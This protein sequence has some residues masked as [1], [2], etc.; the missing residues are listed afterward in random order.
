MKSFSLKSMLFGLFT[1]VILF[2]INI[3]P[4]TQRN[5]VIEYATGTWC[6]WC[7]CGDYTIDELLTQY[8]N[9]IPI[10]YHGPV[11]SDPFADF[12]GNEII[13]MMGFTGYPTATVDRS[14][15]LG[16]YTTWTAKVQSQINIPATVTINLDHNYNATTRQVNG[17]FY[18]TSLENLS[19]QFYLNIILTEDSLIYT[20]VNNG[21]CVSGGT[22]WVHNRVVRA[23]IN[24]ASGQ[25]VN[26]GSSWN[27]GETFNIPFSYTIPSEFQANNCKIIAFIYKQNSP[28]Y[29]AEVQQGESWE[30]VP[31]V[32]VSI[33]IPNGGEQ[34]YVGSNHDIIWSDTLS[35]NVKIELFK[36]DVF[37]STIISSTPSSGFYSWNIPDIQTP[38]D[39]YK[40][41]ISSLDYPSLNDLSDENFSILPP[42]VNL[43]FPNGGESLA[44]GSTTEITW[45]S[46]SVDSI[47]LEFSPDNGLSWETII[48]SIPSSGSYN[49]TVPNISSTSCLVKIS[50]T[51]NAAI[52]DVSD[53]TF[54]IYSISLQVISPNGGENWAIGS[55][56]TISWNSENVNNVKIEYS[57]NSGSNWITITNSLPNTGSYDWTIPAT[58]STNCLVRVWD[59]DHQWISDISDSPF[60]IYNIFI[61]VLSP[62]GGEQWVE[63][64]NHD[65]TYNTVNVTNVKIDYSTNSGTNWSN[66]ISS[67]PATGSY[68]WN[69]PN[70]PSQNCRIRIA[71]VDN[72]LSSDQ[73]DNNFLIVDFLFEAII[74]ADTIWLDQDYDGLTLGIV[75]GSSSYINS[76]TITNYEW[77]VN[78]TT[79]SNEITPTIE[80]TTGSNLVK[81]IVTSNTGDTSSDSIYISVYSAK[82]STGGSILSGVSQL[83][84]NFYVTSMNNGVYRIDSTGIILQSYMTGG[85]I[86]SSLCISNETGLM[87]VGS[88]DTRLYCFDSQLNSFWDR[89][90]GGVVDNAAGLTFSGGT[91]YVG[92][93]DNNTHLGFLKSLVADNGNPNWTFQADG[94]ILSS[95]IVFEIVDTN[96][97]VVRTLIYF[98]TEKG[99]FYA[100]DDQGS[101]YNLFWS[102]TTNPDSAFISSPAIS[103]EGMI[104][105]GS[106]N[107][108][109]YRY[110]WD[111]E[112]QTN[113]KKYTGGPITSSPVIDENGIVYIASGSGYVYG[114]PKDFNS[115]SDPVKIF[116]QNT[117]INGTPG[118]GPDGTFLIGCNNGKFFAL[119]KNSPELEMPVKWY[120][121]ASGPIV[122]PALITQNGLIY[123]G[124]T[125]G[126]V[127]ILKDPSINKNANVVSL[128]YE[129]PTF[130]GDNQ[131]S[132]VVRLSTDVTGIND[133][134]KTV[135]SFELSQNY[136]NPFN[137]TTRINYAVPALSQVSIN[138]YDVLGNEIL[139]LVNDVKAQGSYEVNFNGLNLSS[140][141]YFYRIDANAVEGNKHFSKVSKM[142]L[143][144]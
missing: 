71:D 104:Y 77:I 5:P 138:V 121:K 117:G 87:Y 105:I 115:D 40:I 95:P 99:T 26:S 50:S 54:S 76:G 116:Q 48:N 101:S 38:G 58:A 74:D 129:W 103:Q 73:S 32:P 11:G 41:K 59:I 68:S 24:S 69:V 126:D 143:L 141:I 131:R 67:V 60:T 52:Y 65:I 127:F 125:N 17:T 92:T 79:V 89:A 96:S 118:I 4:Q 13:G 31:S 139:T 113:W 66:I 136:P 33:I 55:L 112:H 142:I 72:P 49:W 46:N 36:A 133:K 144:K 123:I 130:K 2:T 81:L 37:N 98:G 114:Y 20:Q 82:L 23:M 42:S 51:S 85:G 28:L 86:R 140:G 25:I 80:L 70:T 7:P 107:G 94:A 122:A 1:S 43:I 29:L 124:S 132:K 34:W 100:L 83:E 91:V 90:L 109:M 22:N 15:A 64:S 75:D 134:N 21:V 128:N 84:N 137:P 8:P 106:K 30:L 47:N 62:N 45:N 39:D 119:D 57:T 9:L 120:F 102:S 12:P 27:S 14:S 88:T 135:T 3:H 78:G 93:N 44:A 53:N 16:D 35:G 10:A 56:H 6:Q 111:G 108:Y 61:Q 63:G 110:N 19:G 97:I 18:L